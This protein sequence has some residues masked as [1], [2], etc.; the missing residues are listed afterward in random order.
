M[1]NKIKVSAGVMWLLMLMV[2]LCSGC[3]AVNG[4]R[5]W[6]DDQTDEKLPNDY[7]LPES[8]PEYPVPTDPPP[9]VPKDLPENEVEL[10]T[11]QEKAQIELGIPRSGV[12]DPL[13]DRVYV[14]AEKYVSTDEIVDT[15]EAELDYVEEGV[16]EDTESF[17]EAEAEDAGQLDFAEEDAA[18]NDSQEAKDFMEEMDE[19]YNFTTADDP[20]GI[21]YNYGND[22][23]PAD[24]L[25]EKE[26][27]VTDTADKISDLDEEIL[28]PLEPGIGE[29]IGP[30]GLER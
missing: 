6:W 1:S 28:P 10:A 27:V 22:P 30:N 7:M 2:A 23:T 5:Y 19:D 12:P 9:F 20:E 16:Q 8:P 24:P 3:S 15:E 11:E 29:D 13:E 21:D 26:E 4:P 17:A 18:V 25:Y 14:P